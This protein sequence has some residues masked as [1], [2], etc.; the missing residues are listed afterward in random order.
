LDK[1]ERRLQ[2]AELVVSGLALR[3]LT[4]FLVSK[5]KSVSYGEIGAVN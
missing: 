5:E 1:L 2:Q 3:T 4:I